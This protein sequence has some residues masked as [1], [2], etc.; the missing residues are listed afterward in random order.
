[1]KVIPFLLFFLLIVSCSS[2]EETTTNS[3]E[4]N[5]GWLPIKQEIGGQEVRSS[6]FENQRLAIVDKTFIILGARADQGSVRYDDGKMDIHIEFG[7]DAGKDYKAIY[8]FEK[9]LLTICY[10]LSGRTY[11]ESFEIANNPNLILSVYR[12]D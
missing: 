3:G 4:L 5:G 7:T 8:K 9:N 12:R 2:T 6:T 11:P 1:M 10:D